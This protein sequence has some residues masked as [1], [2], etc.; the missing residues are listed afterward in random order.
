MKSL[1]AQL[2]LYCLA[3]LIGLAPVQSIIASFDHCDSSLSQQTDILHHD[4]AN[5]DNL[6]DKGSCL[7]Y[8]DHGNCCEA[9][10]CSSGSCSLVV[11]ILSAPLSSASDLKDVAVF[12]HQSFLLPQPHTIFYRPPRV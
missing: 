2:I 6:I 12:I 7:S 9:G 1:S 8:L 3:L 11:G 4:I 10:T 5:I